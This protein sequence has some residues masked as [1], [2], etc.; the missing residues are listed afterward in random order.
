MYLLQDLV[1]ICICLVGFGAGGV[2]GAI[3]ANTWSSQIVDPINSLP[4]LLRNFL[5]PVIEIRDAL[6]ATAVSQV[7]KT[8]ILR[9]WLHTAWCLCFYIYWQSLT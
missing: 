3:G 1:V 5:Q 6:A 7:V 2:I 9:L 8:T 4:P